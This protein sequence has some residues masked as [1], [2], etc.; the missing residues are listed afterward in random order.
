ML[1]LIIAM[2]VHE[3]KITTEQ[4]KHLE[5]ENVDLNANHTPK[6]AIQRS[7]PK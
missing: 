6:Q 3:F 4:T 1:K 2:D 5:K 7:L